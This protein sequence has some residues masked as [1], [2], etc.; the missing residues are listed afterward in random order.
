[1]FILFTILVF[2]LILT[3]LVILHEAGHYFVAKKFGIKVE[4]FGFGLPPRMWGKKIGETIYS[5][6]WLPIGGFVK[7][8]GEDEAGAGR[9]ETKKEET[10]VKPK[11]LKR[12]YFARPAWQRFLIVVAGIVM[13]AFLA[14]V[15]YYVFLSASGFKAELP[16]LGQHTFFLTNQTVKTQV[17]I[18]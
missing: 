11:D 13:N 17:V 18:N 1:M 7:L 5:I 6:N 3:V 15:I 14:V 10:P 9:I 12:A 2:L 8:F 16:L 4:E